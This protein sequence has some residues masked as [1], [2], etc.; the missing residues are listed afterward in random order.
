MKQFIKNY[1]SFSKKERIAV[2]ILV[3]LI[4][5][6]WLLPYFFSVKESSPVP[7]AE[8]TALMQKIKSKEPDGSDDLTEKK[9]DSA[10]IAPENHFSLFVFD[11]NTLNATGWKKLGI[12]DKTVHTILNYRS[13]GGQF[14]KPEDI[15]KIWGLR[16]KD[17][18]RL[19]PYISILSTGAEKNDAFSQKIIVK[20]PAQ[21]IDINSATVKDFMQL[22]GVD[23]SLPYRIVNFREKLGGFVNLSQVK[24]TYGITDSVFKIISPFLIIQN[25]NPHKLNIN[26]ATEFELSAHPYIRRDIAKAIVLYRSQHGNYQQVSDL[27]KIVFISEDILN[28]IA[29]YLI[30]N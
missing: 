14:H 11:P 2:F 23:H 29:P 7:N 30:I 16:K 25:I 15:S 27:R 12:N 17:A 6:I 24:E 28:R 5:V 19:I 3:I 8:L 9:T 18:E 20:K 22:P 21:S 13:K 26:T 1:F 4:T 10:V